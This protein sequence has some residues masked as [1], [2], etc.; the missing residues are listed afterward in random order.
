MKKA[1]STLCCMEYSM[2]QVYDLCKKTGVQG[3]ELRLDEKNLNNNED[4]EQAG[5]NFYDAGITVCD[6]ASSIS[7]NSSEVKDVFY[8]YIDVAEKMHAKGVRIFVGDS[9][10]NT[11]EGV[12]PK[13]PMI[14]QAVKALCAY[15]RERNVEIWVETHSEFSTGKTVKAL[16]DAVNADNLKVIWDVIHTMEYNEDLDQTISYLGDSIVHIHFK[17]GVPNNSSVIYTHT[18]LGKG[19]MPFKAVVEKLKK[20]NFNGYLSLEWESP[21]RPE[22]RELYT[23]PCD[24]I[25]KYVKIIE[26][27]E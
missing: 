5:K 12:L 22:I 27:C 10:Y 15:A 19:I 16:I 4:Y 26:A 20:M 14:A 2:A 23:D 6:I 21:W 13:V 3:V 8:K 7:I 17:D 1:F 9:A 25:N 11:Y 24:L 18:D